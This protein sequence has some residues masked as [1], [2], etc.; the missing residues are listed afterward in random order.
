MTTQEKTI[1][2][3]F[4]M[5]DLDRSLIVFK[6]HEKMQEKHGKAIP[7][8]YVCTAHS[9]YDTANAFNMSLGRVSQYLTKAKIIVENKG[10]KKKVKKDKCIISKLQK[11]LHRCKNTRTF[12]KK[13]NESHDTKYA[14]SNK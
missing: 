4:N 2:D 7:G 5:N 1:R 14:G 12:K 13:G 3:Y 6:Y 9:I 8:H 11:E 10:L